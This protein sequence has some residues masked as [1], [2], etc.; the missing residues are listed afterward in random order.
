MR[1][2]NKMRDK[3]KQRRSTR[4]F[5]AATVCYIAALLAGCGGGGGGDNATAA[6][7]ADMVFPVEA[8]LL[9]F[10]TTDATYAATAK[11][12]LGNTYRMSYQIVPMPVES[13]PEL[14]SSPLNV[15]KSVVGLQANNGN[16]VT[17][18][19]KNYFTKSP[20]LLQGAYDGDGFSKINSQ[21][22]P[23]A[24]AK[25]GTKGNL[26]TSTLSTGTRTVGWSLAAASATTAWLCLDIAT[27]DPSGSLSESDCIR[28]DQAG[29]ISGFKSTVSVLGIT[30][31]F[32]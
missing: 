27:S 26:G 1:K 17:T 31:S 30:L 13:V 2:D 4:F 24:S 8:A 23:P 19:G 25:V 16:V 21:S 12:A 29:T 15:F 22:S 14:S 9:A 3:L 11:D 10:F 18:T 32:V 7:E 5:Q 20:L 6:P 28:I